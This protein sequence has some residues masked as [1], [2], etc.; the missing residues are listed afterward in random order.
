MSSAVLLVEKIGVPGEN[1]RPVTSHSQTLS[2]S[3]V[4]S[5]H[6]HERGS[7][8][9]PEKLQRNY[10]LSTCLSQLLLIMGFYEACTLDCIINKTEIVIA[11]N[12]MLSFSKLIWRFSTRWEYCTFRRLNTKKR[13][14]LKV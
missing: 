14:V 6:R 4:L 7:N 3:V 8:I 13:Q 11:L 5:T 1:H 9:L 2:H 10:T 12:G